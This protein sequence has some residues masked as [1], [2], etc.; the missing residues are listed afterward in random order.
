MEAP[1]S[2]YGDLE[3]LLATGP[4]GVTGLLK[5]SADLFE[6]TTMLRFAAELRALLAAAVED[7]E[8]DLRVL[9]LSSEK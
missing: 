4:E 2:A 3:L 6:E 8:R 1:D 7:P 9:P 5:Y